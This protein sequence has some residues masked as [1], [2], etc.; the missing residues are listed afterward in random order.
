[1]KLSVD[2][3][4]QTITIDKKTYFM[5]EKDEKYILVPINK[6]ELKKKINKICKELLPKLDKKRILTNALYELHPKDITEMYDR[7]FKAKRKPSIKTKEGC[8]EL[9]VGKYVIPIRN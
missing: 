2:K 1:M 7:L 6:R 8:I 4:K 3:H 5:Y 9:K